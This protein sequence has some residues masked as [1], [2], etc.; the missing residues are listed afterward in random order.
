MFSL[1][2]ELYLFESLDGM[3]YMKQIAI[4]FGCLAFGELVI[5]F[6]Q[7]IIPSS[8]IGLLTLF[9]LLQLKVVKVEEVKGISDF[10]IKNMGIFFVPPCVSLMNY[11]GILNQSLIPILGATFISTIVVVLFTGFTHQIFRKIK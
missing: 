9:T 5:Y 4:I 2:F 7:L 1:I 8:I 3:N 10:L 11:F 6:T